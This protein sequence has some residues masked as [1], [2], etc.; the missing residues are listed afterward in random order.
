MAAFRRVC[1]WLHRE[2]GFFTVGLTLVY[3]I[4]GLAVNHS[5]QWN[6]NYRHRIETSRIEPVGSGPT[7]SILPLV[8]ER[9]AL[10]AP[11]K[12]SWR[13]AADRMQ[14]FQDGRTHS[15]NLLTGEVR[16]ESVKR[17]PLLFDLNF[18]HLNSGKG[19]WTVIADAY[20]GV[21]ALLALTGIFLTRGPKGL[22]GRGGLL[23]ALGVVLPLVYALWMRW[24]R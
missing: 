3:A 22:A 19:P 7:D 24:G 10:A 2:L 23:M 13:A 4:S 8:L 9:L 18:M 21:L 12:S 14:V 11:V 17:R 20:A 16:S 15:V 1:R 6:A 5:H